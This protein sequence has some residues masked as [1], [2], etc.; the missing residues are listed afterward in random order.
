MGVSVAIWNEDGPSQASECQSVLTWQSLITR[1]SP[2][3]PLTSPSPS[4]PCLQRTRNH[5]WTT[6]MAA[7][8]KLSCPTRS[9]MEGT[10]SSESSGAFSFPSFV[11]GPRQLAQMGS[12]L[13]CLARQGLSVRPPLS[14]IVTSL[15]LYPQR[16]ASFSLE[17]RQVRW[18]ILRDRSR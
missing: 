15:T 6:T 1:A 11:F 12:L 8:S 4:L 14:R 18:E 7:I 10:P 13:Y 9:K 17:D 3:S 16:E 2:K 5:L